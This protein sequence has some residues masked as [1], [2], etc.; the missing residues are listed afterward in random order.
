MSQ[1]TL[2]PSIQKFKQFVKSHPKLIN[3]VRE[4]R[5][6]WQELYEEWYLLGED[7][8]IWDQ[9]KEESEKK[10]EKKKEKSDFMSTIF[11]A[12]KGM[13]LTQMEQHIS[14]VGQAITNIQSLISQFK[15]SNNNNSNVKQQNHPFFF[16]KD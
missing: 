9:F 11:T 3:E 10:T 1:K 16:N 15:G 4:E 14:N 13:D 6:T 12:V 5:K 7:D 2:H 8:S